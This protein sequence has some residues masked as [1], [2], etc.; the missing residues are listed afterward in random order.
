MNILKKNKTLILSILTIALPAIVEMGLNTLVNIADTL[1][2]GRII[3]KNGLAAAGFCNELVFSLIFIFSSFNTGATAMVARRFGEKN[4]TEL[5]KI[6][7]QNLSLN[8][9]VGS[10]I[11]ILSLIFKK[12][13]IMVY[14]ISSAVLNMSLAYFQPIAY[15]ILFMF[16]S[17]S[18]AASLRG[19]GDT[20]T[21]ML[22]TLI[23]NI[24]NIIGNYFLM[25]GFWIFPN[26][27]IEGAAVSTAFSRCIGMLLYLYVLLK[28]KDQ[29]KLIYENLKVTKEVLK[30]LWKISYPGAIE[31]LSMNVSFIASSIIISKLDT[32]SEAAFRILLSIERLSFMPA[33]GMSIA[34]ATLVGKTLG[35][36]DIK[37]SLDTGYT[38]SFLGVIWGIFIGMFFICFPRHLLSI[39]TKELAIINL[40]VFAMFVAGF[41]QPFLNFMIVLSGALRGAG[42]TKAVMIITGLRAWTMFVPLCYIFTITLKFGVAGMWLAE[43]TSFFVFSSILFN[44]FRKQKWVEIDL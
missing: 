42:D 35:E 12:E 43:I 20:K 33:V 41:N 27:G 16:V 32:A 17:F 22:I 8:L 24:L 34:A 44:R 15:S 40:S 10:I 2:I 11:F 25:T 9:F 3:G 4:Y 31:Q 6:T 37:K 36:K 21:P 1:M 38:V 28:G 14:D 30:P 29:C 26:M 7:G 18:V 39:F 13:L 19:I 23:T 5:N